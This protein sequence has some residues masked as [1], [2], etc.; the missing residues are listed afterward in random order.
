MLLCCVVA[1][2]DAKPSCMLCCVVVGLW[3][4]SV[5]LID[6]LGP[7]KYDN[8]NVK[9]YEKTYQYRVYDS[10]IVNH[11]FYNGFGDKPQYIKWVIIYLCSVLYSFVS[12]TVFHV[13]VLYL[14]CPSCTFRVCPLLIEFIL[15]VARYVMVLLPMRGPL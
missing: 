14:S 4:V 11:S 13:Y 3:G 5:C 15:W 6:R 10:R 9:I 7:W 2:S 1:R 8:K 12:C